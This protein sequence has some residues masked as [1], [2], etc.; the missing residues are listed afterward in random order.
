MVVKVTS[1]SSPQEAKIGKYLTDIKELPPSLQEDK[2]ERKQPAKQKV[3]SKVQDQEKN[4]S[5]RGYVTSS[6][7][8]D[9]KG[10]R[11]KPATGR[12]VSKPVVHES[13]KSADVDEKQ[14]RK[15]RLPISSK[16]IILGIINLISFV[17]LV[18]ILIRFPDKA[19]ELKRLRIENL[20]NESSVSFEFSEIDVHKPKAGRLSG[21]F[22]DEAGVVD[23]VNEVEKLKIEGSAF[24]KMTF[25]SQKVVKDKTGNYGIPVVIELK[26]SWEAIGGAMEAIDALPFL[27]RPV[28][29]L[30]EPVLE[31]EGVIMFKY[32]GFLYVNDRLGKD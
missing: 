12:D 20:R 15:F 1:K 32:G 6:Q 21:L 5:D 25:A 16:D 17:L 27:F 23:F 19:Q 2:V 28:N 4:L 31:E 10:L 18:I 30:A 7:V 9:T 11:E 14:R 24:N 26:G 8:P 22:L 29:I 3:D 13:K